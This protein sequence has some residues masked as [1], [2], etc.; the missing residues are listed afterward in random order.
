MS[1]FKF[2]P[3]AALIVKPDTTIAE[4]VRQMK[5]HGFGAVLVAEPYKSTKDSPTQITGIFTERDLLK[6]IDEIQKGG[7]WDKPVF[8]LM[9]KPVHTITLDEIHQAP[10][11]MLTLKVRHLPLVH[12]DKS[13]GETVVSMI[14]MRDVLRNQMNGNTN[15]TK[16]IPREIRVGMIAESKGMRDLIRE[17]CAQRGNASV[18]E[19]HI[20]EIENLD[21]LFYDLDKVEEKEWAKLLKKINAMSQHP[22][23]IL[24]YSPGLHSDLVLETLTKL[25][26]S[27]RF[28]AHMKPLN[29]YLLINQLV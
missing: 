1:D 18:E 2:N 4:C 7:F 28:S 19:F 8:L 20:S 16:A 5:D 9:S 27:G 6:W 22:N 24:V 11:L 3:S 23:T 15:N 10:E 26:L 25:K 17:L 13:T 14:S 21:Y 12:T 29:L